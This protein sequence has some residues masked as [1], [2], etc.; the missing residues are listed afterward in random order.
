MKVKLL[1]GLSGNDY[2][3]APGD[4]FDFSDAEAG[5][6]IEAGY[7]VKAEEPV[8][9][10]ITTKRKGKANVVSSEGDGKDE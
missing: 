2:S 7:A 1:V 10:V 8:D 3:L 6:L 9:T 5:R 4:E